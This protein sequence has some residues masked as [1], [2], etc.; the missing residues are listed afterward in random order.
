L[1]FTRALPRFVKVLPTD[2]KRV[3]DEEAAKAAAAKYGFQLPK[4]VEPVQ[5]ETAPGKDKHKPSMLDMEDS[6]T[7][8]K[9]E[10]K[11]STLVLNKTKGFMLYN[12]RSE[13]YRNAKTRTK[14]WAELSK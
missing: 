2:Y 6:I 4:P 10:K 12:R 14:D 7:D 13:K 11:K 3:L 9:A 5:R 8:A 1:E